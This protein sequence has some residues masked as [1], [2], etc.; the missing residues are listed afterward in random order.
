[1][2]S[3]GI[4]MFLML[5][6]AAVL[7]SARINYAKTQKNPMFMV[8]GISALCWIIADLAILYVNNISVNIFIWNVS[9][10]FV[11]VACL[12][13]FLAIF[14]F[15]LPERKIPKGVLILLFSIPVITALLAFTSS[16]HSLMR[17][18]ESITVWPREVAY[19]LGPWF[20][21]HSAF[22]MAMTASSVVVIIYALVKKVTSDRVSPLLCII[23]LITLLTGNLLYVFDVLPLNVN[24]T[25]M[26]GA[27]A[28]VLIHLALTESKYSISFRMFNTLKSRITF[29]ILMVMLIM[30]IAIFVYVARSTRLLVEDF[31]ND[32]LVAATRAVQAH[33]D[34][35]R[36][37]TFMAASAMGS[38][39]ELIRLI[40]SGDRDAVWRYAYEMKRH[41]GVDEIIISSPQGITIA[42]SHMRDFF[43]D[44]VS[45]VPSVA[46]AL[47]RETLTLYTPTPTAYMVMTSTSP[48][49]DGDRLVGGVVVNYVVA[50]EEF[51][52][53]I[54]DTFGVD[55]TVF[56]GDT[57]RASTLIHPVTGNRAVGT[58]VAQNVAAAVL[59][60][61][62]SLALEL[63]VFGMLPFSAYYFP[64]IGIDN[65]P[66]GMFF[67][68]T[69]QGHAIATT[70]SQIRNML[71]IA[72]LGIVIVSMVMF[73]LI[74]ATLKPVGV[75]AEN[76][77]NIAAGNIN[78]NIDRSKITYDEI[79]ML[80]SDVCSLVDVLK[81][82]IDDLAAVSHEFIVV[83]DFESRVDINKYQNSFKEM[84]EGIHN[85]M[86]GANND[87][88][89]ILGIVS[90]IGD[91]NFD[92]EIKDMP[93]KK[94]VMPQILR[95]V[96]GNL[97]SVSADMSEMINAAAKGDFSVKIDANKYNGDWHEI[98]EGLNRLVAAVAEP[99]AV[100]EESLNKMKFG[101]F[102]DAMIDKKF[103]GTFENLKNALNTTD[104]T[105]LFYVE[106][107]ANILGRMAKGDL[108]VDIKRSYIGSY[109]PIK[110]ALI[111][112]LDSLNNTMSEI[113]SAVDQVAMGAEQISTSA[114]HLAEGATK[115]TASIEE[116][117]ASLAMIHEKANQASSSAHE[118]NQ[119]TKDS[120]EFAVSGSATVKLMSDTMNAV[121]AS[122]SDIT[123]IIDV[124]TNIAFQTNLLALNASVEAARAGEH[125]RGFSVVASEVRTLAGRSQQ[126]ASDT[127][128][129]A[130]ENN[131]NVQESA[132]AA[133]QVV[134]SFETIADNIS[135]ISSIISHMADISSDQ[136][137]SISNINAS[138]SEITGVVSNTSAT[139]EE[140]AA[141]SQELSSQA[142]MLKQKVAFFE[143]RN[144]GG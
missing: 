122:N 111:D 47:R 85:I 35:Y 51:V 31:E 60:R 133:S 106:D 136:L 52:D 49:M 116:L 90:Q 110:A 42:R 41:L 23:A 135:Q 137:D 130:G 34:A 138:V 59:E 139:A 62:E 13:L 21:V 24:P 38:N 79:G 46:A 104:R 117:S 89:G 115:Q 128:A 58:P 4:Y 66:V 96:T 93:G 27:I 55:I 12:S 44:D 107:I 113:T 91:G 140:S 123:K 125:G 100:I 17:S 132:K 80:T 5:P 127:A 88:L 19:T 65:R 98:M 14:R 126:S 109:A 22:A 76:V 11:A 70:G 68:G 54:S 99:L 112:I 45:G 77:K 83:G 10:I 114:M 2:I 8:L 78:I 97:N 82:I 20:V 108:T 18:V 72:M 86:D 63:N 101:N 74:Y 144:S 105:T 69:Y 87:V 40:D 32:R 33:L 29:P 124:I 37:Q 39:S 143:L 94:E 129:I 43:G 53:R 48:I 71:L 141:A 16:F 7:L 67:I 92:V 81:G 134:A 9:A 61:G 142:E 103:E 75:L 30:I 36:H 26:G 25:S 56:A 6:V 3:S 102:E 121:M 64:L 119:S 73:R 15:F 57:A 120:Q 28:L 118:A 95:S 50:S 131:K 1:M 84:I